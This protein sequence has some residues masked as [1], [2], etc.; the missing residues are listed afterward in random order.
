MGN[1]MSVF[2]FRNLMKMARNVL[3]IQEFAW[4]QEAQFGTLF[5][6]STSSKSPRMLN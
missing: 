3:K 1:S 4:R 2:E 5:M 6:F